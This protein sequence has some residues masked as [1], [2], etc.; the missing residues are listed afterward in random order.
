[1]QIFPNLM[2]QMIPN[3]L[4]YIFYKNSLIECFQKNH[5]ACMVGEIL[6]KSTGVLRMGTNLFLESNQPMVVLNYIYL[7]FISQVYS[8]SA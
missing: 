8:L 4:D 7:G 2:K 3:Y 5:N 1:M 6:M